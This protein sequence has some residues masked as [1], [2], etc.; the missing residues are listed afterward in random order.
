MSD[1][2]DAKKL[3][4]LLL[5]DLLVILQQE[6]SEAFQNKAWDGEAWAPRKQDDGI[7][8]LMVRSSALRRGLRLKTV[9]NKVIVESDVP[10]ANIHNQGG[11]IQTKVTPEMR[12]AFW[13]KWYDTKEVYWKALAL[14]KKS[15]FTIRIPKR[16]FIGVTSQTQQRWEKAFEK[17][18][19]ALNL[20]KIIKD[21]I[22]E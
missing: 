8:S 3:E 21:N 12:K 2:I 19:K 5:N 22:K 6:S 16:Q 18:C 11:V 10:Y 9:G 20:I 13:A 4:R 15:S 1:L 17:R 14:T 7:G